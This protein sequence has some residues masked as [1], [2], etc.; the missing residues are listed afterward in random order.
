MPS[1]IRLAGAVG[2]GVGLVG[3]AAL[4][5]STAP[6]SPSGPTSPP[7][8]TEPTASPAAP[9][10]DEILDEI[11]RS[12]LSDDAAALGAR[13]AGV[14]ARAG[15]VVGEPVGLYAPTVIPAAEWTSLLGSGMRSLHA[16][17]KDPR[18]P[19]KWWDQ[20]DPGFPRAAIFAAS[21]DFD[22]VL[23]VE[24]A[25]GDS[26]PWRFS[27][28]DGRVI[29]VVI[30]RGEDTGY[31]ERSLVRTLGYLTPSP[32]DEPELFLVIPPHEM[33]PA[34]PRIPPTGSARPAPV[35]APALAP[36]G[37]TGEVEIDRIIDELLSG[38]ATTLAG[39][40][41][42]M[43]AR[44]E[45]CDPG[46]EDVR[47]A[48]SSWTARLAAGRRS[49]YSVFT[50]DPV[51]A[52]AILAVDAG[53]GAEAWQFSVQAGRIVHVAIHAPPSS[54]TGALVPVRALV[55]GHP[56]AAWQYERFYVLPPA[57]DLPQPPRVHAL[58]IR[59][60]VAGV[61]TLLAG[62]EDR[63]ANA[64][65]AAFADPG[66]LPVRECQGQE[67]QRD[68]AYA[69]AWSKGTATQLYG[70]HAVT[71]LPA[72][73]QPRADHL[74]IV[75]R[76]IKP[77]WWEAMGILE[78]QGRIVGLITSEQGCWPQAMYPIARYVVPPPEKGLAGLDPARRSGIPRIDAVLD[79]AQARDAAAM[80]ALIDYTRE[81]C[82]DPSDAP[83]GAGP[84]SCPSGAAAGTPVEILPVVVCHGGH[85]TRERAPS[86]VIQWIIGLERPAGLYAVVEAS[87]DPVAA[88]PG[89]TFVAVIGSESGPVVALSVGER[90]VTR[91][92]ASCGPAHPEAFIGGGAPS[93][94]L[95][96][97]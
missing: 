48:P 87:S 79:A 70:I 35:A 69:E 16:V 5:A 45:R 90:G 49:L 23:V 88:S 68:A 76:Q 41:G 17:V 29:D 59:T 84:P 93:Y 6:T 13:F 21:R 50:G 26:R 65:L 19:F 36:G 20:P 46:C 1:P 67:V 95:P 74:L 58:S 27:V 33:R 2:I 83:P 92:A 63:D 14:S 91:I 81:P 9:A 77:Y 89:R 53:D 38:D 51:D 32:D 97:P 34:P 28:A 15:P 73:Y 60:G 39:A 7:A 3:L 25:D 8:E 94:L 96:P 47:V 52:E 71:R 37:R 54:A 11:I 82:G 40:Y 86:E 44:Q 22:I 61:D 57:D 31:G 64:L 4:I 55:P 56:S 78:M 72:G 12:L 66:A 30:D 62:L 10:D 42:E 85:A 80:D 43:P 75:F 24:G 18:E